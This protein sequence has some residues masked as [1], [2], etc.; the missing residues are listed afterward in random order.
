M[1]PQGSVGTAAVIRPWQ[2]QQGSP[3]QGS[4]Q[5]IQGSSPTL[6]AAPTPG[7]N[8]GVVP[9]PSVLGAAAVAGPTP[10]QVA[11]DK[12]AKAAAAAEAARIASI[13]QSLSVGQ[14]GI[15]GGANTTAR[16]IGN[17]YDTNTR[18]FITSF[19]NGQDDINTGLANNQLNLRRSMASIASG[20]RQGLRSGGV[21]LANMNALDS[22][23]AEALARA[24]A[25]EGN[26]QAGD[27]RNQAALTDQDLAT[28]ETKLLRQRDDTIAGLQTYRST[29]AD[30]LAADV[31]NKLKVLDAQGRAQGVNG[32]VDM[33]FKDRLIN[34]AIDRLNQID[35]ERSN[36]LASVKELTPDEAAAKAA[37]MDQA[38]V[39]GANPFQLDGV[40]V[41]VPTGTGAPISQL[42][43]YTRPKAK[44]A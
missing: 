35:A 12:A 7:L 37:Q 44:V 20:V 13:R 41:A 29:E 15:Q 26:Q 36:R 16:D 40:P 17:T 8:Q 4:T 18:N 19:T 42:P 5:V 14:E 21:T 31:M 39:E 9:R 38:G 3:L 27:A 28:Q 33:S 22:G 43:I 24:Y 23:A 34:S 1:F 11:A 30:R 32:V 10:A 2:V 25:T 6:Q